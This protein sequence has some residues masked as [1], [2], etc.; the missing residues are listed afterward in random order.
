MKLNIETAS[1]HANNP[2]AHGS[3]N[4]TSVEDL[5]QL[6]ECMHPWNGTLPLQLKQTVSKDYL[7]VLNLTGIC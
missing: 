4:D 3:C 6:T 5:M 2:I 7:N 1:V